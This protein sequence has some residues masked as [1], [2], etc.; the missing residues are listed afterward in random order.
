MKK[1][2]K[3]VIL[4]IYSILGILTVLQAG[5]QNSTDYI[6]EILDN[7]YI[8]QGMIPYVDFFEHHPVFQNTILSPLF[9]I[10]L[11][12]KS[13]LFL[14]E[15][16]AIIG[17]FFSAYLVFLIAKKCEF[18]YPHAA[19]ILFLAGYTGMSIS[20]FRYE[21]WSMIFLLF[22]LL[23]SHPFLKGLFL[24]LLIVTSPI[25]LFAALAMGGWYTFRN[26]LQQ[27]WKE[28]FVIVSGVTTSILFWR[29]L[30]YKIP[31]KLQY[32]YIFSFN[33]KVAH[34]YSLPWK[35][36]LFFTLILSVPILLAGA[37]SSIRLWKTNE[38]A[39]LATIFTIV[40]ITQIILMNIVYGFFSRIKLP[41]LI[42][43]LGILIIFI[44]WY[45]SRTILIFVLGY[46]LFTILA[47]TPSFSF[48]K[49]EMIQTI[50]ELNSCISKD[51]SYLFEEHIP[52]GITPLPLFRKPLEYY[53]F[54][55]DLVNSSGREY[56]PVTIE[57]PVHICSNI[58]DQSMV[59]CSEQEVKRLQQHCNSWKWNDSLWQ[60]LKQFLRSNNWA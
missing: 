60:R 28:L 59:I 13:I 11:S 26:I 43:V 47:F 34:L 9:N 15:L 21:Y 52:E 30:L 3:Y 16:L 23:F 7:Y 29:I 48:Q 50:S 5:S 12:L 35:E 25:T 10:P 55:H 22:F 1:E 31:L 41:A 27:K 2:K 51:A 38:R 24:G 58:I 54:V 8:S 44:A 37:Y 17:V 49:V 19:S 56:I 33:S 46:L 40:F 32:E 4:L 39:Q 45:N 20:F 18:K 57:H 42:P 53:W 14:Y 36:V 6:V